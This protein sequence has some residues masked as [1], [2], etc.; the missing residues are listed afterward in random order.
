MG[1]RRFPKAF[2]SIVLLLALAV[3][4]PSA[5][6]GYWGEPI[7][8]SIMDNMFEKIARQIEG[9]LLSALKASA[10]QLL[11]T[12]VGQ[13]IGGASSGESAIISDWQGFLYDEPEQKVQ[14]Y[15]EDFFADMTSG[16]ASSS[17]YSGSSGGES[18]SARLVEDAKMSLSTPYQPSNLEDISPDPEAA[19]AEGDLRTLNAFFANPMNNPF[20][21]TLAAQSYERSVR[22]MEQQQQVVQSISHGFR[23][24]EGLPGSTIGQMVADAQDIGNKI[25]AAAENPGELASGMIVSLVNKTITSTIQ[26]GIGKV[27]SNIQREI[28]SVDQQI[29]GQLQEINSA[30][31]PAAGFVK[32]VRQQTNVVVKPATNPG[33]AVPASYKSDSSMITDSECS[34]IKPGTGC[35]LKSS[36]PPSGCLANQ[37]LFG[38]CFPIGGNARS[39][40]GPK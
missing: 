6:A 23:G 8:A 27:Q 14:V 38:E 19:L 28:N 11:N 4:T 31:G 3:S 16:R 5:S 37:A 39:C 26:K 18:Y 29:S 22:E 34:L 2:A 20:G 32:E 24:T 13:L 30:L 36:S 40:C 15:M 12:Q 17:N 21:F 33:S 35:Y 10:I 1:S 7:L 25:I 9:A